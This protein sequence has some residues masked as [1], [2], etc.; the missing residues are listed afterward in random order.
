MTIEGMVWDVSLCDYGLVGG[1]HINMVRLGVFYKFGACLSY[2]QVRNALYRLRAMGRVKHI[3]L[4][5][6]AL[7]WGCS[8]EWVKRRVRLYSH[9]A[10]RIYQRSLVVGMV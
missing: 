5:V 9:V 10:G 6:Y 1:F 4:G 3:G 2:K 8:D 7:A